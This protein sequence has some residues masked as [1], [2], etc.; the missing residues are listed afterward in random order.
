MDGRKG[1][2]GR[3]GLYF[4]LAGRGRSGS[5]NAV[6]VNFIKCVRGGARDTVNSAATY[7]EFSCPDVNLSHR[8]TVP[9]SSRVQRAN[10]KGKSSAGIYTLLRAR[11]SGHS[12]S[13]ARARGIIYTRIK[14]HAVKEEKKEREEQEQDETGREPHASD[15]YARQL[16]LAKF[17]SRAGRGEDHA[18]SMRYYGLSRS[19]NTLFNARLCASRKTRIECALRNFAE[20]WR[21]SA[22]TTRPHLARWY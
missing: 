12:R 18:D 1:R 19:F 7:I 15:F 8:I 17:N 3:R 13:R 10:L 14:G 4:S 22:A 6:S 16:S 11:L 21:K 20:L 2:K 5:G 9:R